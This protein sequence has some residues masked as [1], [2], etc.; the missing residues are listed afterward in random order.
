M[1]M[2][3]INLYIAFTRSVLFLMFGNCL[4]TS[5]CQKAFG[6]SVEAIPEQ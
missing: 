6:V 3:R 4:L 2:N 1:R 5:D